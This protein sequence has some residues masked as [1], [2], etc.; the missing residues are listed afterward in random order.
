MQKKIVS[1]IFMCHNG[2]VKLFVLFYFVEHL[3]TGAGGWEGGC[4]PME[5]KEWN[6]QF[7][8]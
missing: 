5:N 7:G 3:S 8:H 4:K 1:S 6:W 2:T